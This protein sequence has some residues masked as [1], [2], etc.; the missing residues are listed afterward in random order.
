MTL[1]HLQEEDVSLPVLAERS[2]PRIA[3]AIE[4]EALTVIHADGESASVESRIH[5]ESAG[6][7]SDDRHLVWRGLSPGR[8]LL[9]GFDAPQQGRY[10][11]VAHFSQ[12]TDYGIHRIAINDQ[13][14]GDPIDLF[15]PEPRRMPAVDLGEFDLRGTGNRLSIRVVS[16]SKSASPKS[17][18]FGLDA[19]V[20]TP[21]ATGPISRLPGP[22]D[23]SP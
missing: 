5:Q 7:W 11:V 2:V 9:L 23:P 20:L 10:R 17:C 14:T 1:A 15:H 3:G 8:E 4:G 18:R 13:S 22:L 21:V 6:P 16:T 12:S 19:L